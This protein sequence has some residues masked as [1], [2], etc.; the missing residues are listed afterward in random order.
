MPSLIFSCAALTL[1]AVILGWI[2]SRFLVI[3]V[4]GGSMTPALLDRDRLLARKC[5]AAAIR[6]GHLVI[7]ERPDP[8]TG[9]R[10]RGSALPEDGWGFSWYVKRAVAIGGDPIPAE[11]AARA[12]VDP[13]DR[14]PPGTLLVMGDNPR[15][16][17][18]KQ[19][20]PCPAELLVA[21]VICKLPSPSAAAGPEVV[22]VAAS[23]RRRWGTERPDRPGPAKSPMAARK[24]GD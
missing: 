17:D 22:P 11:F 14:V 19:W 21:R 1:I 10:K 6:A 18:S 3:V 7:I 5:N 23:A 2:R 16:D 24:G 13:G 8:N 4:E 20:G 12:V 9:W 15:S